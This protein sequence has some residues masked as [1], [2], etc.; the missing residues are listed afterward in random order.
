MD[1]DLYKIMEELMAQKSSN[2][3][4]DVKYLGTISMGEESQTRK[5]TS[6]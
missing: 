4:V 5:C 6:Y 1:K 2:K 3:T